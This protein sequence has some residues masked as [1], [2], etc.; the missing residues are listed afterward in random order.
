MRVLSGI[1]PSGN[2]HL[3][4]Y[5]GMMKR[6]IEYQKNHELF[7]FI[8]NL[9]ALTSV[10][11]AAKLR[12]QTCEAVKDFIALGLDPEKS[13][14]WVQSD[15][16]EVT[17]LTWFLSNVTGMGLLERSHSY[18]D[19]LAK[20]IP[21]STGLFTYPVLMAADILGYGANL[22][23]VGKDQKQHLEIARDIAIRFN[24]T[25]GETFVIPEP[26]IEDELATIP[27]LDGQKMS[28]SYGNTIEIFIDETSL[29]QKIMTLKTD[30]TP[31]NEPKPIEGNILFSL[32]S[33]FLDERGKEELK[34][35][36]LTPGLKYGEVK[37]ELLGVI[38]DYFAPYRE[39]RAA[40]SNDDVIG[41]MRKGA[42][43]ARAVIS[44]Y[45][46]KARHNVGVDYY[47]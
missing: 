32:Y 5:F 22:V 15:V 12:R 17:E 28:K 21:A 2:L 8:V 26:D 37:K 27:G 18:K 33:L 16:P 24:N 19:K 30:S 4:N 25:Y 3:G 38:W 45:L 35:R 13:I 36:F 10:F 14:F 44:G 6:M 41:I 1:Q 40:I 23:P 29:K 31:V 43:K 34:D 20:G 42:E 47:R 46:D 39:K 11:D 7:C 9:H